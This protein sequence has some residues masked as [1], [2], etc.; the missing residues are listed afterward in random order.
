MSSRSNIL[1]LVVL[2]LVAGATVFVAAVQLGDH[3]PLS[4]WEPGI[5]MEA[6][7]LDAGLPIYETGHATHLYGPLLTVL[8]GGVF[9]IFGLSFVAARVTMSIFA[10]ALAIFLSVIL[11]RAKSRA[12]LAMA[13]LLFL[14]I[15]FRTNLIVFSTQ[16]DW[17]AA[18]L[19]VVSLYL[20]IAR[21]NSLFRCGMSLALLIGG[22]LFKQTAASFALIP[23]VYVLLWK[24]PLRVRDLAVSA[25]P[26]MSILLVLAA[27]HVLSPQMFQSIVIIP[28]S[29]KIYPER[30]LIV[31]LYL[32]VAF[33]IVF[34]GLWSVLRARDP[35]TE[36][37]RWI[38]SAL[39]VLVPISIWMTCKSGAGDNSLLFAYLAM[40]ALFVARQDAIFN[41][42]HSLSVPRSFFAAAA[43][44]L[45]IFISCFFQAG[46]NLAL[47]SV[48]HGD[49]KYDAAVEIARGLSG[50]VVSPQDPTLV[51]RAKKYFGRSLYFE[52]DAHGVAGNWPSE[53]PTS[54]LQE[55][56]QA[57][58]VIAVHGYVP[59][60]MTEGSLQS[61]GFH[62]VSFPELENSAY[63]VWNK[64]SE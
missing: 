36:T 63:T 14:G 48:R 60:P 13:F 32:F 12:C 8:L 34:I 39:A 9:K 6:L 16:P 23:I 28:S 26:T 47:L 37:E 20:W 59:T 15:N 25:L 51:Y 54:I 2:A 55:L 17:A 52:L 1:L 56:E 64:T 5:A 33:P 46:H 29:I 27:I 7:R 40:T 49:D 21:E 58:Y 22:T 24:R 35:M 38:L 44:A 4:P 42:L 31:T 61:I 10:F 43:I 18:F 41:W 53:L 57:N 45:T 11:C 3:V 50:T 30:A 62:Q 19:A